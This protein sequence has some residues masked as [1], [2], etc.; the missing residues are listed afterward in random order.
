MLPWARN[1]MRAGPEPE[2]LYSQAMSPEETLGLLTDAHRAYNTN[3]QDLLLTALGR[4]LCE[5]AG[6]DAVLIDVE[7]H[8]RNA[9]GETVDLTR[10]VGWFTILYPVQLA[11]N[12]RNPQHLIRTVKESLRSV[13]DGGI[14]FGLRSEA[15]PARD[16]WAEVPPDRPLY[17]TLLVYE[18]LPGSDTG[19]ATAPAA[20]KLLVTGQRLH[21]GRT[22]I[23]LTLLISPG[24]APHLRLI[25]H[26]D[27]ISPA[28][29][30]ALADEL[31]HLIAASPE[32]LDHPVR[33][34]CETV[35]PSDPA[36]PDVATATAVRPP[37][38]LPR[39][40]LEHQI[41]EIWEELFGRPSI[42]VLDDFFSLGGHSLLALKMTAMIR[43]RLSLELPLHSLFTAA[44]IEKQAI[45][46]SA[47]ARPDEALVE[48][49]SGGGGVPLYC[50]HPL[51]GHV[52]CYAALAKALSGI[53]P[54]WGLQAKGLHPPEEP[55][56]SW[57]EIVDHQW[58][59]LPPGVYGQPLVL[60]GFSYGGYIAMEL[61]ARARL[62]GRDVAVILLD[63][64]HLSV[65]PPER[66]IWDRATILHS[67]LGH[68]LG[69]T[70]D[71]VRAIPASAMLQNLLDMAIAQ[72]VMAPDLSLDRLE[73]LLRVAEAHCRLHPP[74]RRY[75]S[76]V[77]QL[78]ALEGRDRISTVP[79]LGWG[80]YTGGVTLHW[81]EGSHET[82]LEPRNVHH[83]AERIV[84]FLGSRSGATK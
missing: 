19:A 31:E 12:Q 11:C 59:L 5:M 10:S 78:R 41:A 67:L 57:E 25:F 68:T 72:H 8:G 65:I 24:A 33:Q 71:D 36:P 13:P 9:L 75:D 29:V 76:P 46:L 17:Q 54:S 74:L 34:Y 6:R 73:R 83:V 61:A 7:G 38:V 15:W 84:N 32:W 42:S 39:N 30:R 48:L 43:N 70:L 16:A 27:C 77:C 40:R 3:V 47:S 14:G 35:T 52:L 50:I 79:D 56:G 53:H 81:V 1:G 80:D 63:V 62:R 21:G 44:T 45:A 23:P 55:A 49:A 28:D 4:E 20:P 51:G 26:R 64:A 22:T 2:A 69:L 58:N 18:N 37:L 82:M 66:L 60:I